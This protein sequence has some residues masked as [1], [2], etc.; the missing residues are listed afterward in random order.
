MIRFLF[1]L[2]LSFGIAFHCSAQAEK[3]QLKTNEEINKFL[4]PGY[5]RYIKSD[6][7]DQDH[8]KWRKAMDRY[9]EDHPPFPIFVNT[10]D[11]GT[12]ENNYAFAIEMWF[13]RNRFYPQYIDTGTPA[14]DLANW[15][16]AKLEWCKRYPDECKQ[17]EAAQ[18]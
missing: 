8:K 7:N 4:D 16:K 17:V 2:A 13:M 6:P 15:T 1:L 5:P 3:Y 12:D 11:V 14:E 18:K 9:A 10:G